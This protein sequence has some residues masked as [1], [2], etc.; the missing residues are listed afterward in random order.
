MALEENSTHG[1]QSYTHVHKQI[2]QVQNLCLSECMCVCVC[3]C[4]ETN[5]DVLH[6]AG[7]KIG[8]PLFIENAVSVITTEPF[9]I[10]DLREA[11]RQLM[12]H[13]AALRARIHLDASSGRIAP[14]W[15]ETIEA[16]GT[17]HTHRQ[18]RHVCR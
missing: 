9:H 14:I 6:A 12:E 4:R 10:D 18:T 11:G 1:T 3:L 8:R 2:C 13:H 5:W 17:S 15:A 16:P 7:A